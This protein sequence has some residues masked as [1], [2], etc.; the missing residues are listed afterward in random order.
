MLWFWFFCLFFVLF[1]FFAIIPPIGGNCIK[2]SIYIKRSHHVP[3]EWPLNTGS[4]V[5]SNEICIRTGRSNCSWFKFNR[6]LSEEF[7]SLFTTFRVLSANG[8]TTEFSFCN[9]LCIG[10]SCSYIPGVSDSRRGLIIWD[11]LFLNETSSTYI[12]ALSKTGSLDNA[13]Q[14]FSWLS[15]YRLWVIILCAR[16]ETSY[17]GSILVHCNNPLFLQNKVGKINV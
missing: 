1:F 10:L 5:S 12:F 13:V 8:H 14:K 4:A 2:R 16:T 7:R 3:S 6:Y 15:H 9:K 17:T 11:S